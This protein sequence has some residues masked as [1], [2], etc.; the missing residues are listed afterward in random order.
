MTV[1]NWK[2]AI[3]GSWTLGSNWDLGAVPGSND[4]VIIGVAGAYTV[5]LTASISV[6]SITISD[7][8]ATLSIA[9]SRPEPSLRKGLDVKSIIRAVTLPA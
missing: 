5:T 1:I 8:Q 9:N 4:D 3:S 7:A 2:T 6:N